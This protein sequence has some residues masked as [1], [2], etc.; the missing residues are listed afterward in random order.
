MLE[1]LEGLAVEQPLDAAAQRGLVFGMARRQDLFPGELLEP[2]V[3]PAPPTTLCTSGDKRTIP[4][5]RST[6]QPPRRAMRSASASRR[7]PRRRVSSASFCREMSMVVPMTRQTRPR[8]SRSGLKWRRNQPRWPVMRASVSSSMACPVAMHCPEGGEHAREGLVT[9]PRA[10]LLEA[11]PDPLP[12][13]AVD[14]PLPGRVGPH[15]AEGP[16]RRHVHHPDRVLKAGVDA[17]EESLA[18]LQFLRPAKARHQVRGQEASDQESGEEDRGRV[19]GPPSRDEARGGDAEHR[20]AAPGDVEAGLVPELIGRWTPRLAARGRSLSEEPALLGRGGLVCDQHVDPHGLEV[21]Q[22]SRH[23][24]GDAEHAH[25]Q[26]A[27]TAPAVFDGCPP[28]SPA[29]RRA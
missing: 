25:D 9:D 24:V 11:E 21:G 8:E 15:G 28:A 1:L 12:G 2:A 20:P 3:R 22:R 23:H 26:A 27:E 16:V 10:D 7:W 4:D 5:R 6:S 13:V 18:P 14:Q 29:R 19:P 17:V